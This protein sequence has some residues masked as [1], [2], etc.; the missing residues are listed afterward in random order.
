MKISEIKIC[1]LLIVDLS[2]IFI[3]YICYFSELRFI[4]QHPQKV[5]VC[6]IVF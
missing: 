5:F 4:I 6:E 2:Y 3:V 1:N